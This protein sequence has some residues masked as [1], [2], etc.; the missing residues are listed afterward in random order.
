MCFPRGDN[1][2]WCIV[3]LRRW[4][5]PTVILLKQ[6][7]FSFL[8][9]MYGLLFRTCLARQC[10]TSDEKAQKVILAKQNLACFWRA[11]TWR[12]GVCRLACS[13]MD[14]D[15]FYYYYYYYYYGFGPDQEMIVCSLPG[16]YQSREKPANIKIYPRQDLELQIKKVNSIFFN[17]IILIFF[18][19]NNYFI[20]FF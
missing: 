15:S 18:K 20:K 6:L 17:N 2:S 10:T 7:S 16:G 3:M 11:Q 5:F 4:F 13:D 9:L 1:F 19:I 12:K 8:L 14:K